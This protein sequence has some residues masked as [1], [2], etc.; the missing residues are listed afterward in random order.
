MNYPILFI[1]ALL[2]SIIWLL[3]YLRK[4]THPESNRMVIKIFLYGMLATLPVFFIEQGFNKILLSLALPKIWFS[5]LSIFIGVALVEEL[6]KYLVVRNKV[7]SDPE[8]DEPI[9]AMLYMI[10]SALGFAA[11]ENILIFFGKTFEKPYYP[12]LF[13]FF[14]F[15]SAT[16][17]HALCSGLVGYY[18]ARSF[19]VIKKSFKLIITGLGMATIFHGLYNFSLISPELLSKAL[20]NIIGIESLRFLI[21]PIILLSLA[22]FVSLGLKRL[23]K[24]KSICKI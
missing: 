3:F 15:I 5:I 21:P 13:S 19:F 10:I 2:P 8:F 17:L 6:F 14:R 22:I 1:F 12:F 9:D 20:S 23:K 16:F 24:L 11:M 18:L 7:L 4:D